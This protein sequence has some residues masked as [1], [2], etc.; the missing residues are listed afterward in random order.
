MVEAGK[1]PLAYAGAGSEV[2]R[3]ILSQ[4]GHT[5]GVWMCVCVRVAFSSFLGGRGHPY[6]RVKKETTGNPPMSGVLLL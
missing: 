5:Q 2:P 6:H 4:Q 3:G 1:M